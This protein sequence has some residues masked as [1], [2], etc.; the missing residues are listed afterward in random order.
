MSTTNIEC[1]PNRDA[2]ENIR[3]GRRAFE[4]GARTKA[5]VLMAHLKW[6]RGAAAEDHFSNGYR[7]AAKE[8]GLPYSD[9]EQSLAWVW[10]PISLP[11]D[12]KVERLRCICEFQRETYGHAPMEWQLDK[13]LAITAAP[14]G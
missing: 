3:N 1:S 13:L 14:P 8:A 10:M 5:E 2:P 9:V 7:E 4:R 12:E 11:H 6:N